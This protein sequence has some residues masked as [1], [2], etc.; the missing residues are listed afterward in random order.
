[1]IHPAYDT[2]LLVLLGTLCLTLLRMHARAHMPTEEPQRFLKKKCT[3][4]VLQHTGTGINEKFK[5]MYPR[6]QQ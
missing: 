3:G 2:L 5:T 4:L 1:M 6:R